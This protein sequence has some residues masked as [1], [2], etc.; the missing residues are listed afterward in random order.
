[1]LSFTTVP[2]FSLLCLPLVGVACS[3]NSGESSPRT[4]PSTALALQAETS[5][6][7]GAETTTPVRHLVVIFQENV[8]FDHYFGTYPVATNPAGD[9]QF[10][11][12]RDTPT[13][14]GLTSFLL[15]SNP[16][17]VNPARVDRSHVNQ[18]DQD[19]DYTAEQQ[20][21]DNGLADGFI[22]FTA[23]MATGC[24]PAQAMSYFD[25]NTVTAL[26]NYAQQFA[27]SDNSFNTTYGPSTP[28]AINLVSGQTHG[29]VQSTGDVSVRRRG[30]NGDQRCTAL[31]RRLLEP[32][33]GRV[34]ASPN[35]IRRPSSL[36][37]TIR[38]ATPTT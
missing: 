18:C 1:M 24:D 2:A 12:D 8:S 21:Y 14:N 22:K 25:G 10:V 15:T 9:P 27:M 26:W 32:R 4:V 16:N 30:W 33:D 13:V 35:G 34:G 29:V 38:M 31:L 37:T 7:S 11:A 36:R 19:H 3:S 17:G 5:R 23:N 20:A 6:G 28:G